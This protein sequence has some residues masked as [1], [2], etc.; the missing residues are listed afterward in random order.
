MIVASAAGESVS[1][2]VFSA[3]VAGDSSRAL[4]KSAAGSGAKAVKAATASPAAACSVT[5]LEELLSSL[6][7][8]DNL[9]AAAEWCDSIGAES[10][11][12]LKDEDYAERL[13][14]QLE[15][16]EIICVLKEAIAFLTEIVVFL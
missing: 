16:K 1:G 7:L 10:V 4:S 9:A 5:G 2:A 15:L 13:A 12:D 14:A 11:D 3:S 6:G 8:Q